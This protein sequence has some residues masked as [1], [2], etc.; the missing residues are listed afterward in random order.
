[1]LFNSSISVYKDARKDWRQKKK[2][3][4]EGEKVGWHHRFNGHELEQTLGVGEEWR[5]L[6]FRSSWGRKESETTW[7]LDNNIVG[8]LMRL[9]QTEP[10]EQGKAYSNHYYYIPSFIS[11]FVCKGEVL[12]RRR[13]RSM[14]FPG[15]AVIKNPPINARD[16]RDMD[17]IPGSG[18][19]P[20]GE[21]S[22]WLQY[23]CLENSMNRGT[24]WAT[25]HGFMESP[26][27]D[28]AHTHNIGAFYYPGSL[29][30]QGCW[31]GRWSTKN[32]I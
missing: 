22:N 23:F 15:D 10:L 6:A 7:R 11:M 25:V 4:T 18:R 28:W 30:S 3:A 16:A 27:H 2:R 8:G 21:H 17:S 13:R 24:W 26:G 12:F 20:G 1:M 9:S 5:V 19:C 14:G 29:I 32:N 31:V